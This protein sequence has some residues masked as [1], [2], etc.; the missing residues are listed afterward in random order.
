MQGAGYE[1]LV[2]AIGL[3]DLQDGGLTVKVS[4]ESADGNTSYAS[5]SFEDIGDEW[6]R[7]EATL[8][9]SLKV[10]CATAGGRSPDRCQRT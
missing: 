10:R 2:L 5:T 3:H 6:R 4:L 7:H 9:V 8:T 1:S